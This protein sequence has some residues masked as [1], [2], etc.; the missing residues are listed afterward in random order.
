MT[1][2]IHCGVFTAR[3]YSIAMKAL[4]QLAES[5]G[6]TVCHALVSCQSDKSLGDEI[7]T[8]DSPKTAAFARQ[9]SSRNLKRCS[10]SKTHC[11]AVF[12]FMRNTCTDNIDVRVLLSVFNLRF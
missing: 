1:S 5:A 7:L 11:E 8:G 10:P 2:R 6:L 9:N 4:N 3:R 12:S